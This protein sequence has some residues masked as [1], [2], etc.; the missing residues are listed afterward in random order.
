VVHVED[1]VD[2]VQDLEIIHNELRLKDIE[3]VTTFRTS[4]EKLKPRGLSK[5]QKEELETCD[6]L[7]SWLGEGKDVR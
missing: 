2:P 6:K 3:R 1:R 4:I 7:L 5:E